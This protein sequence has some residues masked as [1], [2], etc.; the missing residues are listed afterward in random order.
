MATVEVALVADRHLKELIETRSLPEGAREK[1]GQS[2]LRLEQFPRSGRTL[3]GS[4]RGYRALVGPWGWMIA[5]YTYEEAQDRVTV[6]AFHDA[7]TATAATG[8]RE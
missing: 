7:R 1:V 2:L 5:V 3:G 4:W 6:V 8:G